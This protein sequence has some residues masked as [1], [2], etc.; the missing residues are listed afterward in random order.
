MKFVGSGLK[1]LLGSIQDYH[2][3]LFLN[4]LYLNMKARSF[5]AV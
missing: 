5:R 1:S 3:I 2:V 4:E